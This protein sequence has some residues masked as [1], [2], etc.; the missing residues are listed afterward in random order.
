MFQK[1]RGE[2]FSY[3]KASLEKFPNAKCSGKFSGGY[4]HGTRLIGKLYAVFV[5]DKR[6]SEAKL[7]AEDAWANFYYTHVKTPNV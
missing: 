6:M 1:G 3:K 4:N 2:R 7:A 5:D